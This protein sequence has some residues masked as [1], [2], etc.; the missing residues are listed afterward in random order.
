MTLSFK[1][2]G[3]EPDDECLALKSYLPGLQQ[4]STDDDDDVTPFHAI[5]LSQPFFL[6]GY[7]QRDN[8]DYVRGECL[9]KVVIKS[10]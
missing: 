9:P 5:I 6:A 8:G 10:E 7:R 4:L 3:C 1:A 2:L